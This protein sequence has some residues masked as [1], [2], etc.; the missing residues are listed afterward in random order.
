MSA[1]NDAQTA[2]RA[3]LR[4]LDEDMLIG[5]AN[6]GLLRRARG[7]IDSAAVPEWSETGPRA[8][9]E[10]QQQ[11]LHGPGF[12][13]LCC[14]CPAVGPCHHLLA[15]LLLWSA[16]AGD[17]PAAE[18]SSEPQPTVAPWN[19]PDWSPL[20][21]A[22]GV[23]AL[24]RASAWLEDGLL[25]EFNEAASQLHV[26]LSGEQNA[27]LRFDI[28][29]A[30]DAAPCSCG[31]PRCAHRAAALLAWRRQ[32]GL[33]C[34]PAIEAPR[35]RAEVAALADARACLLAIAG[36]GLMQ[37]S[38][39]RLDQ[40][41]ALAQ[42]CRQAELPA[43]ARDL[44]ALRTQLLEE[45]AR[46]A[47]ARPA[48][49]AR[50]LAA[51]WARTT[52]LLTQPSP[53]PRRR[54][55]GAHRRDYAPQPELDLQ[56]LGIERWDRGEHSSGYSLHGFCLSTRRWWRLPLIAQLEGQIEFDW[57][58]PR[59]AGRGLP[60]LLGRRLRLHQAW[61]SEDGSLSARSETRWQDPSGAVLEGAAHKDAITPLDSEPE[62]AA[63]STIGT[64]LRAQFAARPAGWLDASPRI[65]LLGPLHLSEPTQGMG[66]DWQQHARDSLGHAVELHVPAT[67]ESRQ[68][69][70]G[71]LQRAHA[72]GFRGSH[73]LGW[74]GLEDG[75]ARI[76]P[77]S[78]WSATQ[79]SWLHPHADDL[80]EKQYEA[81]ALLQGS[82]GIERAEHDALLAALL[83]TRGLLLQKLTA[84]C[85][86]AAPG[87][88]IAAQRWR[89]QGLGRHWPEL[90]GNLDDAGAAA[91]AASIA[92]LDA[93]LRLELAIEACTAERW[94]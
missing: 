93:L 84:G 8:A 86:Q 64:A 88:V 7:V 48:R 52:A 89:A 83:A 63:A 47:R 67:S 77:I 2:L 65:A 26:V 80:L 78:L 49:T 15:A 45:D 36:E 21:R 14:S 28:A 58:W 33:D 71:R 70:I 3:W 31:E 32:R 72:R 92:A 43:P 75:R 61:S 9:I 59:W 5:W 39:Q 73:V 35:P 55:R 90:L 27:R 24:R 40:L 10:G 56:L 37:L 68:R 87:F 30:P 23:H 60:E 82:T 38:Q 1:A 17:A 44:L 6:R 18:Q 50:T 20:Q 79:R 16:D 13:H 51:A 53:Q 41:E 76:E 19:Q 66:L 11:S 54:L 91:E 42:R 69:A 57:R 29:L 74:L 22:L 4:Q 81:A 46:R 94:A 34:G 25:A 62:P 12:Q 85:A